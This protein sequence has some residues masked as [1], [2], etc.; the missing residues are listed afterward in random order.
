MTLQDNKA[1]SRRFFEDVWNEGN[2]DALQQLAATDI[3]LHDRDEGDLRG[4]E[5][6]RALVS[7]YRSAF[8]DLNF[9]IEEQIA[10]GDKV[11]TL[12]K[13]TG[14]HRGEL[15]GIP[16]TEKHSITTGI[17]LDRVADG[18]IAESKGVWDALGLMQQLGVL[19][20]VGA[21]SP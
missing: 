8:P 14:T 17:T 10:E 11:A 15:M 20:G 19:S 18:K 13:A 1:V 21:G 12:W 9:A 3:V 6:A 16:P 2:M 7:G 4:L 5:A